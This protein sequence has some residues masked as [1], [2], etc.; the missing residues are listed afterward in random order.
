MEQQRSSVQVGTPLTMGYSVCY[1]PLYVFHWVSEWYVSCL[2][3][4]SNQ[5]HSLTTFNSHCS[6]PVTVCSDLGPVIATNSAATRLEDCFLSPSM[7]RREV[8]PPRTYQGL[9]QYE[10]SRN[11]LGTV[12][13]WTYSS[14]LYIAHVLLQTSVMQDQMNLL[15]HRLTE[16]KGGVNAI[17]SPCW[18]TK[19][20]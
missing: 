5:T 9:S 4:N 20:L 10:F 14:S 13:C 2:H 1:P 6:L 16:K 19:L 3:S 18:H 15:L 17:E 11:Y 7:Q 8:A 12:T